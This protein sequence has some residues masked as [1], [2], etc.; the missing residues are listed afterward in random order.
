VRLLRNQGQSP[1]YFSR[2]VGGNFRLDEIQAAILR[3][4]LPHLE[5]WTEARRRNAAVYREAFASASL[6]SGSIELP[7]E[8]V[9]SRHVYNQFVVRTRR[10]DAL[11]AFLAEAQIGCE[12][13][14]PQ[15]MH[16]QA[17]FGGW[18][19]KDGQFPQAE[20]ASR[21]TLALPIYPELRRDQIAR[22]VAAIAAFFATS[23]SP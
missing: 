9:G 12:V 4:K 10:R 11:R 1:K 19:G 3:A 13:Y 15:P 17:C 18:G 6:P 14:Y 8:P 21:E 7:R 5:D 2:V 20:A 16:L 22:V 23:E